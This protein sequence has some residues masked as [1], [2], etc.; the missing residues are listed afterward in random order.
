MHYLYFV[1]YLVRHAQHSQFCRQK[2]GRKVASH[3]VELKDYLDG[4]G[5]DSHFLQTLWF[6]QSLFQDVEANVLRGVASD[7]VLVL[8]CVLSNKENSITF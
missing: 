5:S 6:F 8:F 4:D 3:P 2:L 7:S 1:N